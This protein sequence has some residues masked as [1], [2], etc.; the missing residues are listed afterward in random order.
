MDKL[1]QY[2]DRVCCGLGGPRSLRQHLRQEL[3]EHI[4]DAVDQFV[5]S[6]MPP[7]EALNKALEDFGLPDQL[8]A[9]FQSTHG[10]RLATVLIDKAMQ[11]KETTM[12]SKFIW[13][14][15]AHLAIAAVIVVQI[16][17]ILASMFFVMPK[18]QQIVQ[19]A[20]AS[21]DAALPGSHAFLNGVAWT[22]HHGWLLVILLIVIG[23][24]FE[25][26]VR[27]ENKT[28]I[29]LTAWGTLA[30]G[31]TA[32]AVM[33][34]A[35]MVIPVVMA[36]PAFRHAAHTRYPTSALAKMTITGNR[37]PTANLHG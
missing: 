19:D 24:F 1:E 34:A 5:A 31:L 25:R 7:D 32:A 10:Q 4:R 27:S 18:C 22:I 29:R 28:F 9:D 30:L 11:W 15:W 3:R 12:K 17:F 16:F 21:L 6:G 13:T 14:T 33:T 36:V 20:G 26:R 37:L 23:V 2:L 8:N 35:V